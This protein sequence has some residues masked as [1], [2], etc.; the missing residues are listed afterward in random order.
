MRL[1]SNLFI[2]FFSVNSFAS[3][4]IEDTIT[5]KNSKI[6]DFKTELK[7]F[8]DSISK[9]TYSD[10]FSKE[11]SKL[12]RNIIIENTNN[13][14]KL[15]KLSTGNSERNNQSRYKIE[16]FGSISR[17]I[18]AGTNQNSV[19]NSELD[20]QISGKLSE[21]ISIKASIQ[22]SN[23]PLQNDGYSQQIDEFDQIF[24]EI[25]SKDWL[26]RGGD[27]DLKETNT[28]FGNF[29]KRIQGLAINAKINN[30]VNLEAAAAIVKGKF[31]QNKIQTQNGNQGPYKLIGQNGELF[32]LIVSGSESVFVNG[33]K[34][35]RGIDKDYIINYNAGEII[36]NT[37]FPIM[38]D[39]RINVEY[40]VSEKNYNT[41]VGYTKLK[42]KHN[43]FIH[44]VGFYNENDIKDQPLIQSFS[45]NQIEVLS[46]AGDDIELMYAPSGTLTTFN[47][48]RILYKKIIIDN[49]EV[50][51]YSNNEEDELYDVSFTNVGQ[52]QGDY[53]ITTNNTI[54]NIYEYIPRINGEKQGNFDPKIR[55]VAPEKLQ[56]FI[57]NST[58]EIENNSE[59]NI[60]LAA[61][62]KDE[63]LFSLINDYDNQGF[64]S[65]INY[66]LEKEKKS[67]NIKT[68]FDI[69]YLDKNFKAIERIYNPEFKRN[70][71]LN[72][73]IMNDYSQ[74]FSNGTLE[75]VNEKIGSLIYKIESLN[76]ENYFKGLK[77]RFGINLE[78][79]KSF[80]FSSDNSIMKSKQDNYASEFL[81][82]KNRAR[83]NY[84]SG[85]IELIYNLEK[86]KSN[87]VFINIFQPDFREELHEL[88][89]GF[90]N[91]DKTFVEIGYKKKTNDSITNN[92]NL[93]SVN[94]YETYFLN[95]QIVN[96]RKTKL[97]IFINQNKFISYTNLKKE[98][99][100]NTKLIYN[101]RLFNNIIDSNLFFETNSGNMPQQEYTYVEVEAGLGSYKW[102][103]VN[104]NNIQELEEFEIAVFADEGLYI[105][106]LLPNQIFI[107]TYENKL[108]YALKFNFLRWN[109]SKSKI[110]KLISRISNQF[111]YTI[112]KKT[113]LDINPE[114]EINPFEIDESS[115]LGY[116]YTLKNIFYLNKSQQRYSIVFTYAENKSKNSFSF[117]ST[118]NSSIIKKL[119]FIHKIEDLYL[120]EIIG[121]KIKKY[122]WSE[123][124]DNKNYR[125]DEYNLNPSI[126]YLASDNNR[127]NF[128]YKISNINNSLGQQ[129]SLTQQNFRISL[130]LN[131][132]EKKGF[133]SE[134]NYYK[135]NFVGDSNSIISYVMMN[136]LQNGENYTWSVRFQRKLSRLIDINFIYQGRNSKNAR[137]VHNGSIQLKAVF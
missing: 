97:N 40:Q 19:L 132:K 100:I 110:A 98:N 63:N 43:K 8:K 64:A 7:K 82:T 136:G 13:M 59:I 54:E 77:N 113:N 34:I 57:Y 78:K 117:G 103:D 130:F 80:Y 21:N 107:R 122:S 119:N 112:D 81:I 96:D 135:N 4:T 66:F 79:G 42:V 128:F 44:N 60:E 111:Q 91:K 33:K 133:V 62:K 131:Q 46:N 114:I 125:L 115:L 18:S 124:F 48:N 134:F 68:K 26:L 92:N 65:K 2:L 70:W 94:S 71:G 22:D 76:F 90:G 51:S 127:I 36:F 121:N 47:N 53:I 58:Y 109:N 39:M 5:D 14:N 27:I 123:N 99:F 86:R 38:A 85:W 11:Y 9:I 52:N 24:I 75:I 118:K 106:V 23:I 17:G 16:T 137:T 95:S 45:E 50:Y 3:I 116:N 41:F 20:L 12:D 84:S 6:I 31:K 102:I 88:K 89:K 120:L 83:I 35:E 55:L 73:S 72:E 101:Q 126:T 32:V 56:L 15:Y 67:F 104:G 74:L 30:S 1:T 93:N 61:S 25:I 28:F 49:Q 105:R 87:G 37:S 29:Q 10:I 69:N 129:E 108:N